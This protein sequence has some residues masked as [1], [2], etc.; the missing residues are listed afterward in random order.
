MT[1]RA[2]ARQAVRSQYFFVAN[3]EEAF[4]VPAHTTRILV[5]VFLCASES[6]L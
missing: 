2:A 1:T 3:D 6:L 5:P 4:S